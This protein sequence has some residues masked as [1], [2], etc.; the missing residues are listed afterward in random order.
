M[1]GYHLHGDALHRQ[2]RTRTVIAAGRI[3]RG[4]LVEIR[5]LLSNI[6]AALERFAARPGLV[7][8]TAPDSAREPGA[9]GTIEGGAR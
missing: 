3:T 7:S 8:P 6:D 9:G 4:R 5:C 1:N 2:T